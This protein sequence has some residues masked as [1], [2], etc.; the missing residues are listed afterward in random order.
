[1]MVEV[2]THGKF[3]GPDFAPF[4]F[5]LVPAQSAEAGRQQGAPGL[6]HLRAA[7]SAAERETLKDAGHVEQDVVLRTMLDHPGC[8]LLEI[9]RRLNWLTQEGEPS[10]QK[11]HRLMDKLQKA[12]LVQQRH[13]E[14]YV[15]T[16]KGTETAKEIPKSERVSPGRQ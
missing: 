4:S 12:K 9:A 5:K 7:V 14:R 13:D 16:P 3:R 1:M 6:E 10:K 15:L 2:T 11:V 8:S